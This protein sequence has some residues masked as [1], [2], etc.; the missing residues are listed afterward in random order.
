MFCRSCGNDIQKRRRTHS[1]MIG[2]EQ[3]ARQVRSFFESCFFFADQLPQ[4]LFALTAGPM[5]NIADFRILGVLKKVRR[6]LRSGTLV[7]KRSDHDMLMVRKQDMVFCF[8][9]VSATNH[10]PLGTTIFELPPP[11]RQQHIFELA[12]VPSGSQHV[13]SQYNNVLRSFRQ[14]ASPMFQGMDRSEAY[15]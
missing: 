12:N 2:R 6:L 5:A 1:H 13:P 4:L 14:V 9:S 8:L 3:Y 7:E 15:S 11:P 10:Q